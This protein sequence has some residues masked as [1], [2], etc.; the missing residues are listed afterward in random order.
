MPWRRTALP[1]TA[2]GNSSLTT[3]S[4]ARRPAFT[5]VVIE[6]GSCRSGAEGWSTIALV[7]YVEHVEYASCRRI[8]QYLARRASVFHAVHPSDVI[9]YVSE[10]GSAITGTVP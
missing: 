6:R 1:P 5:D 7:G 2:G 4:F 8:A 3:S 9:T 10:T